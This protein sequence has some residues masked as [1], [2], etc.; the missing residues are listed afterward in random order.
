MYQSIRVDKITS[1]K[2]KC[3]YSKIGNLTHDNKLSF[4]SFDMVAQHMNQNDS[5]YA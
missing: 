5:K 4:K 2:D 3:G 1:H